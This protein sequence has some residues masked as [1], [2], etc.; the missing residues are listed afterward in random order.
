MPLRIR[1]PIGLRTHTI[2]LNVP[3]MSPVRAP[4]RAATIHEAIDSL[5]PAAVNQEIKAAPCG[6]RRCNAV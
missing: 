1:G 2:A 6:S 3:A 4:E 5:T